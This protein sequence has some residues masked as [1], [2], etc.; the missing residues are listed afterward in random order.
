MNFK[1]NGNTK[2]VRYSE[3]EET[4]YIAKAASF[5]SI[6]DDALRTLKKL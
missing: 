5:S 1:K 3:G 6:L 2:F 4:E